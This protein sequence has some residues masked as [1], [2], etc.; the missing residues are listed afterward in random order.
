MACVLV[1]TLQVNGQE[2][3]S[4]LFKDLNSL[5]KDRYLVTHLWAMTKTPEFH[6]LYKN[7]EYDENGEVTIESLSKAINL[8]QDFSDFFTSKGKQIE[9]GAIDENGEQIKYK[10]IDNATEKINTFNVNN[11][12]Q[13]AS[14]RQEGNSFAIN[15]KQKN[16]NNASLAEKE[17][18]N[19]ALNKRLFG[20]V[21]SLGFEVE[22][23]D[24]MTYAGVFNPYNAMDSAD[25]IRTVIR[26][27]K[28]EEGQNAFPEE[29]AHFAIAGLQNDALVQRL[30]Q[31]LD[32]PEIVEKILG[33]QFEKYNEMYGGNQH[34]LKM[35]AAGK[36]LAKHLKGEETSE[37]IDRMSILDR[38]FNFIRGM[39]GIFD[40]SMIDQAIME[41][42]R[43]FAELASQIKH[44][45]SIID[46]IDVNSIFDSDLLYDLSETTKEVDKLESLANQGLEIMS[47]KLKMEQSKI[48]GKLPAKKVARLKTLQELIEKK[49]YAKGCSSFLK[50]CTE[51]INNLYKQFLLLQKKD[52]K[53]LNAGELRQYC[54]MLSS[55]RDFS[56][57]YTPIISQMQTLANMVDTGDIN[58]SKT[59]AEALSN[60]ATHIMN[61]INTINNRYK[62]MRFD[63]IATFLQD[64]WGTTNMS[65]I[66]TDK[67]ARDT[68]E[69]MLKEAKHDITMWD[70][71]INS[72]SDASDPLLSLIDKVVKT[73]QSKRDDILQSIAEQIRAI[74]NNFKGDTSFMYERDKNGNLTGRIISDRDF[75]RFLEERKA[76]KEKIKKE[77]GIK[78]FALR[79]EMEKWDA[80]HTET[81]KLN[82]NGRT[83]QLPKKSLYPSNALNTLTSEQKEYYDKM[84]EIKKTLD[85]L[86]PQA[87]TNTYKAVQA[88]ND[89]VQAIGD[90]IGNPKQLAK[91]ALQQLK[92]NFVRRS[93][94][95]EYGEPIVDEDGNV[96]KLVELG[97]DGKPIDKIPIYYTSRLEDMSRLNT[98]F[99]STLLSY[100]AMATNYSEMSKIAN[101]LELTRDLVKDRK[102]QQYSGKSPLMEVFRIFKKEFTRPVTVKGEDAAIGKRIDAYFDAVLYGKAKEDMGTFKI[103]NTEVDISKSLDTLKNY[104]GVLG[105]GLNLFSAIANVTVGK[106]QLWIDSIAGSVGDKVGNVNTYFNMK[107][108]AMAKKNYYATIMPYIAELNSIKKTSKLGLLIDKFDAM[109]EFHGELKNKGFYKGPLSRILGNGSLLFMQSMGE[110][111][112]HTR[113]MLAILNRQKVKVNGQEMSMY[114]AFEVVEVEDEHSHVKTHT[115]QLK[116]GTVWANGEEITDQDLINI[117]LRIG[118]VNQSLNGAFNDTD[119]GAIH[120]NALGRLAMQFRQW[121]PAHYARR[122]G[123]KYY[124]TILEEDR[125]GYYRT[126]GRFIMNLLSDI[127]H[128]KFNLATHYNQLT[129]YEKTNLARAITE[130]ALFGVLTALV[131]MVG[132]AKDKDGY[133]GKKMLNYQLR[134]MKL[135]TGASIPL[136]QEFIPNALAILQSPAA[137]IKS[138][139]NLANV[140]YFWNASIEIESGRWKGYSI[141]TRDVLLSLP[142]YGPAKKVKEL[143]T[144][145]YMFQIFNK[146]D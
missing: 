139:N 117:K 57:C 70:T 23:V 59:E 114:D 131:G 130:T 4:K 76:Y 142:V 74:H 120:R 24:N 87:Y 11:E 10:N 100:A 106:M 33:D 67:S 128:A 91:M 1:P 43:G 75:A 118:K 107:D 144:E 60:T 41:A 80:L 26:I 44:D 39:F 58:I 126:T 73:S 56:N 13:V 103:G 134:R 122:F 92:D 8:E 71:Y 86:L 9:A 27:A 55:I 89:M 66:G 96:V 29:F 45:D 18:F 85:M 81:V 35:E 93:D 5:L 21:K 88:R 98:D 34:K 137:A 77:K 36:L 119:K 42:N 28:G 65:K 135:E 84:M 7:L 31:T 145:N 49:S 72:M 78:G 133:W 121:M 3:E 38:I 99:S 124:D 37:V 129:P 15:V 19:S 30:M 146:V 52:A 141:W 102:V 12:N 108:L 79:E 14:I 25:K 116:P 104:T 46:K 111:Y 143:A 140:L 90:N 47:K 105:L 112:L 109:E 32:N 138:F 127:S 68:L 61:I 22:V 110:Q 40:E 94:D 48:K 69:L 82:D 132:P 95:T 20:M 97:I 6:E 125:E 113:T 2:V 115:L 136:P 63:V 123:K 53:K 64:Y 54:F 17:M 62:D 50:D 16:E 83:E 51:E 101:A